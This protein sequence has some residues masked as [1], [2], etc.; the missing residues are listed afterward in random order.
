M[1]AAAVAGAALVGSVMTSNSQK[2]AANT[3]AEAQTNAANTASSAQLQAT[4]LGIDQQNKQFEAIQKL[5]A[6][7]Q[8]AGTGA[9][10][11]QQNLLGLN[12]NGAQ[13]AAID[14]IKNG[15]QF[16]T[17]A[18]QGENAILSNASATG[19]LRGGNV[20]GALAQFRPALLQQLIQ[21]QYGNLGGLTSIGQNAAAGVGNAGLST[22][23][24]ITQLLQAGGNAQ[25]QAALTGGAAAAGSALAAGNANAS[26]YNGLGSAFG[27]YAGMGGFRGLGGGSGGV[28]SN[29]LF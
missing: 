11:A 18:Q 5:L 19:G 21:Q 10:T 15:A 28:P 1:V 14:A 23:N 25:A 24:S 29:E 9:L 2:S 3:A 6:P 26:L 16:G 22:G 13:G 7:Y 27:T 20:Q 17:L 12:G 4:Q 8:Q